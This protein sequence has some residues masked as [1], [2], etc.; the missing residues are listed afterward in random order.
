MKKELLKLKK[1]LEPHLKNLETLKINREIEG[2]KSE[3]GKI[4]YQEICKIIKIR[5]PLKEKI[6]FLQIKINEEN[7]YN[8]N[9]E[10]IVTPPPY[11]IRLKKFDSGRNENVCQTC[12]FGR[13]IDDRNDG[14]GDWWECLNKEKELICSKTN[15]YYTSDDVISIVYEK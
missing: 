12:I 9:V 14:D 8:D 7:Y 11:K 6:K 1:E 3:E 13:Y 15:Y 5:E 4:I 10:E 2:W